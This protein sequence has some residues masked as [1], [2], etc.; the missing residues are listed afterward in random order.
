MAYENFP[1]FSQLSNR[2]EDKT[3]REINVLIK[4]IQKNITQWEKKGVTKEEKR[5]IALAK[6]RLNAARDVRHRMAYTSDPKDPTFIDEDP[7]GLFGDE[8]AYKL[9]AN[10]LASLGVPIG[11]DI[12]EIIRNAVIEGITPDQIAL[13]EPDIQA[14]Q[15]WKQRFPGW[16]TR[17]GNGYNQ[18]SVGEYLQ[19]EDAYHRILQSA[20]LPPGFYD[21][22]SDFGQWIAN[23]VSP[24][25]IEQRVEIGMS[26]VRATDP[27]VRQ[28][29]TQ[30]Y[31]VTAGDLA[32]YFL[33]QKRALPVLDRQYKAA[34]IAQWAKRNKLAVH[35]SHYYESL[36][37]AGITGDQAAQGY[38]TV[39]TLTDVFGQLG[40]IYSTSYN[41]EDAEQ[42]VFFGRDD[43]RRKLAAAEAA[44]FRGGSRGE[45]GTARRE[46][47]Y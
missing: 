2:Y 37:D 23:D 32:S 36:V 20:G 3:L 34:D 15:T 21:Q 12:E 30:F 28:L 1:T 18:L 31:G 4:K 10:T 38:S 40:G 25:E 26:A 33:D 44:T 7:D 14:T 41:Q 43:K 19:L 13:I 16:H 35:G 46:T 45:T 9:F 29:L 42:D 24:A 22:P 47:S 17:T 5:K 8:S 11:P 6:R 27:T 39:R